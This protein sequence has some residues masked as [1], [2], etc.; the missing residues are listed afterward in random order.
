MTSRRPKLSL[1][2]TSTVDVSSFK[3]RANTREVIDSFAN[4]DEVAANHGFTSRERKQKRNRPKAF[5]AHLSI[6]AYQ[7]D[8][9]AFHEL[10]NENGWKSGKLLA[11][12]ISSF[13]GY[14]GV[15]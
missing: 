2:D 1:N 4:V 3:P 14:P 7:Q 15:R 9:D 5:D 10:A 11:E 12:L 6:R 8:I 13:R